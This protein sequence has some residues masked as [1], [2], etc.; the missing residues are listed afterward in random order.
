MAKVLNEDGE[1]ILIEN[2]VKIY[3]ERNPLE[4][5]SVAAATVDGYALDGADNGD[6]T[7]L[8]TIAL[9]AEVIDELDKAE[10]PNAEETLY[11]LAE[12]LDRVVITREIAESLGLIEKG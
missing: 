2:H 9:P 6:Y 10:L 3:L 12:A 5:W 4:T 8:P 11:L 7:D 1:P